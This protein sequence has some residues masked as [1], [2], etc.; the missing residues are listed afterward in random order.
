MPIARLSEDLINQIAAGEVVERPA[1]LLKELLENSIDAGATEIEVELADGA[2]FIK[3]KDNGCG[4]PKDELPLALERHATSKIK[5][6]EDLWNINSF[7]FR[8]E[9]LASAASVS[10]LTL[11]SRPADSEMGA[12]VKVS[13]GKMSPVEGTGAPIGTT[14]IV[15][16]LFDNIPARKKF[17]KS[18]SAEI[19]QAKLV[20]KSVAMANHKVAFRVKV[21]QDLVFYWPQASSRLERVQQVME[22]SEMYESFAEAGSF[23]AHVIA[24]SPNVTYPQSK[25][26]LIF[27]KGRPVQDRSLQT[28][29]I[30]AYRTVLMHGE[31]PIATVFVECAADEVDVNIHP[32][33]SQVKFRDAGLAFR[34]VHRATRDL[35]EKGPWLKSMLGTGA[36][37]PQ[38]SVMDSLRSAVSGELSEVSVP[39][40]LAFDGAEFQRTQFKQSQFQAPR[41]ESAPTSFLPTPPTTSIVAASAE[42]K[43][44]TSTPTASYWSS[45][46]LIGQAHLTYI[47]T[48]NER[49]IIFVDQHAAHERVNF[50]RLMRDFKNGEFEVQNFLLPLTVD[51]EE[52]LVEKLVPHFAEIEKR[53]GLGLDQIGP[54]TVAV[55]SAIAFIK[56]ESLPSAVV[57][58]A[59][60]IDEKGESFE[61]EKS[62]GEIF[63]TMACHSSIRAGQALSYEEMKSLL[64]QMDEFSMSSFCPHGRPV[65]VEYPVSQLERDFGRI[66]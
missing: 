3:V 10:D 31:F 29:V 62:V 35:V 66:V 19:S 53:L 28:A 36:P 57:K 48:Q 1:H 18:D 43:A 59:N 16:R 49:S 47:V 2:R 6:V 41:I 8:G 26:I 42:S 4:I 22:E 54:G 58:M 7:G 30:D 56:E 38:L 21:N 40:S 33:K 61:L 5:N 64:L 13:F 32:T 23:K 15:D 37:T 46:Q 52:H 34:A 44:P 27:V 51:L 45:L 50:E 14:V 55:R 60:E 20:L 65:F 63:A 17:L 39:S 24:C 11:I 9:A 25:K 12:E